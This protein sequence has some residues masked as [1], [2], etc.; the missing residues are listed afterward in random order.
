MKIGPPTALLKNVL[1]DSGRPPS[2]SL[3]VPTSEVVTTQEAGLLVPAFLG[4]L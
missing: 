4:G 3:L 1:Q 2:L